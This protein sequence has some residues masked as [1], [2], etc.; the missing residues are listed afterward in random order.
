[1]YYIYICIINIVYIYIDGKLYELP[2]IDSRNLVSN[3]GSMDPTIALAVMLRLWTTLEE[4]TARRRLCR[5]L[6]LGQDATRAMGPCH[7]AGNG[8]FKAT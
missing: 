1:M 6:W 3:Y 4:V 8:R 2:A 7:A 5:Q